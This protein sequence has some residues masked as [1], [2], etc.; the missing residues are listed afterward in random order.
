[1]QSGHQ[2]E[3]DNQAQQVVIKHAMGPVITLTAAGEIKMQSTTVDVTAAMVNV[4]AP[5][6]TFD[7]IINCS[8]LIA[9]VGVTSPLYS[10]GVGN[11]W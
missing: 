6:A 3:L 10:P 7:G 1:M 5:T 11:L 2:V 8:T 9:K 4:H